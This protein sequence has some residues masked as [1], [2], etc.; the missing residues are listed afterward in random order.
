MN[1]KIKTKLVKKIDK[2][3]SNKAYQYFLFRTPSYKKVFT[4]KMRQFAGI[5]VTPIPEIDNWILLQPK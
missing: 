5:N 3:L 2:Q 1:K 4:Y